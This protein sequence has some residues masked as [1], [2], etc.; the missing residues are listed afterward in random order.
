MI[1][2]FLTGFEP[3]VLLL[4]LLVICYQ[5]PSLPGSYP[6][7]TVGKVKVTQLFSSDESI[8]YRLT[9]EPFALLSELLVNI[10]YEQLAF[11]LG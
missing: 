10:F 3:V 5:L 1:N 7:H 6:S 11:F 9:F 4:E 2:Q 8:S